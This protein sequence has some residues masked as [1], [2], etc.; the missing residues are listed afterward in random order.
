MQVVLSLVSG[1]RDC[2]PLKFLRL[3]IFEELR[4]WVHFGSGTATAINIMALKVNLIFYI[5]FIIFNNFLHV[6]NQRY[7][8]IPL[9][10]FLGPLIKLLIW[11]RFSDGNLVVR[12]AE[13]SVTHSTRR[14]HEILKRPPVL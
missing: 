14:T 5:L 6:A 9:E 4:S 12:L 13:P 10:T 8:K 2:R 1:N 11:V 3:P 7:T